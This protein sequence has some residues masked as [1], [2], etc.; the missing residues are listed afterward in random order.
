[1]HAVKKS[2]EQMM[3]ARPL[4]LLFVID[5]GCAEKKSS[6]GDGLN[7]P[8]NRLLDRSSVGI[9]R[10]V[11]YSFFSSILSLRPKKGRKITSMALK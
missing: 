7:D 1:M 8:T 3:Y 6:G 4:A 5:G 9:F 11:E 10:N 2:V